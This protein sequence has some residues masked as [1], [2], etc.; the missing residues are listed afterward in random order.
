MAADF[1]HVVNAAHDPVVA[2]V[3]LPGVVA[4]EVVPFELRP[5]LLLVTLVVA[6]NAAE[7]SGPRLADTEHAAV[8]ALN[9]LAAVVEDRGHD[10]RQRLGAASGFGGNGP[11]QRRH[12]D[13]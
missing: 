4:R 3:V 2:V 5:I 6:P 1:D 13:P 8:I 7:H 9:G 10:S 11:R 12:H